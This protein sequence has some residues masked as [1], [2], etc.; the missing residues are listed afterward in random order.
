MLHKKSWS[1]RRV[2]LTTW[3]QGKF[4]VE[5]PHAPWRFLLPHL[6]KKNWQVFAQIVAYKS[7][8]DSAYGWKL[9]HP[10]RS[11]WMIPYTLAKQHGPKPSKTWKY[12]SCFSCI[13]HGFQVHST[14]QRLPCLFP[15]K[16]F[17]PNCTWPSRQWKRHNAWWSEMLWPWYSIAMEWRFFNDIYWEGYD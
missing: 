12:L 8:S 6:N 16:L 13:F 14:T 1:T 11:L 7:A 10:Y 4:S 15:A 2:M 5:F 3:I 17:C 9:Y